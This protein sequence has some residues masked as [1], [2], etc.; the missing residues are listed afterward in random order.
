MSLLDKIIGAGPDGAQVNNHGFPAAMEEWAD[1]AADFDRATIIA[2][3]KLTPDD[4]PELD[5]LKAIYNLANTNA[6]KLRLRMALD[7][8]TMLAGDNELGWYQTKAEI[9][10]R[11]TQAVS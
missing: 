3:F 4:E 10:A 1:G 5:A 8:I 9:M 11:L 2:R 6:K 7:N